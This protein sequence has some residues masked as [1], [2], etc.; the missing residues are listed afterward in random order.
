MDN[1]NELPAVWQ[2]R[3]YW[4]PVV[5]QEIRPS[6]LCEVDVYIRYAVP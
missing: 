1:V 2:P 6:R 3:N 5:Y 4:K